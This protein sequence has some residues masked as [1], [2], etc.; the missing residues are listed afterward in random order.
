MPVEAGDIKVYLTGGG[1]NTDPKESRGGVISTTEVDLN[2]LLNNLYDDV[3]AAENA[4]ADFS[5][6]RCVALKNEAGSGDFTTIKAYVATGINSDAIG[7]A[8]EDTIN[9]T[10][11]IAKTASEET[12]PTG[13]GLGDFTDDPTAPGILNN[14]R[15]DTV[16]IAP[17]EVTR[18]WFRRTHTSGSAAGTLQ[19]LVTVTGE[20]S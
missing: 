2:T 19:G 9:D 6:Y 10:S 5:E 4:G 8:W 15:G 3:S 7:L 13:D 1:S 12:V 16:T 14:P 18:L 11:V 17:T 20:T